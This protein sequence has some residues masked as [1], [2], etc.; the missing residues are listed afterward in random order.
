MST[1]QQY[2]DR[3]LTAIK[4]LE[5]GQS[6]DAT[7]SA[8]ALAVFNQ[9]LH[10]WGVSDKDFNWFTQDTLADTAPIPNWAEE[11]VISNLAIRLAEPFETPVSQIVIAKAINGSSLITRT[12]LNLNVDALDMSHLPQGR[13]PEN[14]ILN[15]I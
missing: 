3:A 1:N 10:S 11:G 8:T 14:D 6:A 13:R 5:K 15:D 7:D 2:I 12:L 9:M 4:V